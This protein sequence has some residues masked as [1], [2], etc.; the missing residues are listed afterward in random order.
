MCRNPAQII[1]GTIIANG[2]E[3]A[4]VFEDLPDQMFLATERFI[5]D[6]AAQNS[7]I[8]SHQ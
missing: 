7:Q 2:D 6:D 5:K 3:K 4:S 1:Y 8:C